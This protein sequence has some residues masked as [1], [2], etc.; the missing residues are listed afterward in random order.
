[1]DESVDLSSMGSDESV[2]NGVLGGDDLGGDEPVDQGSAGTES[3]KEVARLIDAIKN[4]QTEDGEASSEAM[5][6]ALEGLQTDENG[7]VLFHGAY[8][9]PESVVEQYERGQALNEQGRVGDVVDAESRARTE[10]AQKELF[11]AVESAIV[12]MRESSFPGL[13][14]EHAGLV[15]EY[16]LTQADQILTRALLSGQ[17]LS[18]E[19]IERTGQESLEKAK[20]LFG[21]FGERQIKDN[22]E[23]AGTYRVK[24]DG[25]PG[26]RV[27][28]DEGRLTKGERNRLAQERTRLAMSMRR[29]G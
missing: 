9:S 4:L 5:H 7:N 17:Q 29:S 19:L 25:R 8:V 16:I 14:K 28:I 11:N 22:Q 3:S 27:P 23:Y 6:P 2:A 18:S 20:K 13:G 21:I 10:S 24:P 12:E 15:D 26:T 1:M